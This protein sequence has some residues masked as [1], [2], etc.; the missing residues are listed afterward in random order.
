MFVYHS[1][2]SWSTFAK[3]HIYAI[4]FRNHFSNSNSDDNNNNFRWHVKIMG[5][6]FHSSNSSFP[7]QIGYTYI[8]IFIKCVEKMVFD[9]IET[10]A[11][12]HRHTHT[13]VKWCHPSLWVR[14]SSASGRECERKKISI[15]S[16]EHWKILEMTHKNTMKIDGTSSVNTMPCAHTVISISSHVTVTD[17]EHYRTVLNLQ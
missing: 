17:H 10:Q 1:N 14:H 12:A 6:L 4:R 7:F 3:W 9:V 15:N 16:S 13:M 2:M 5:I 11:L 8:A